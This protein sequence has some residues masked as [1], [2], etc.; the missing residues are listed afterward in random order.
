[1]VI[2]I[3]QEAQELV[4]SYEK[5]P[6]HRTRKNVMS[7]NG[8]LFQHRYFF[9]DKFLVNDESLQILKRWYDEQFFKTVL[10]LYFS[11]PFNVSPF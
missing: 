5:F 2:R 9:N 11:L 7:K 3:H 1:M 4:G 10:H 8:S 6:W